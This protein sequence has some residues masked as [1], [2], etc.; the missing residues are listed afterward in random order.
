MTN[1]RTSL[2]DAEYTE[3]KSSALAYLT[4]H[5]TITN[6]ILRTLAPVEY[7]QAIAALGR[8]CREGILERRGNAGG[9]HYVLVISDRVEP[10]ENRSSGKEC[11]N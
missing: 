7:D 6:K 4:S 10:T 5:L 11:D 9:T 1:N 3:A 2:T 8:M